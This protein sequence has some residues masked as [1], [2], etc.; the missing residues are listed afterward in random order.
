MSY[1]DKISNIQEQIERLAKVDTTVDVGY[2]QS[3]GL[4]IVNHEK[5]SNDFS[6]F[7]DSKN[8]AIALAILKA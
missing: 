3:L 2:A 6:L 7:S 1:T 4:K 8:T 5:D